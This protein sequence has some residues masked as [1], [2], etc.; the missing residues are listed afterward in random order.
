MNENSPIWVS[1]TAARRAVQNGPS[2]SQTTRVHT[3]QLA[4]HHQTDDRPEEGKVADHG[5]WV[6]EGAD[7]DE[8]ERHERIAQ[9][10]QAR[11]RL[12]GVVRLAD[13]Q[14]RQEGPQGEGESR[15]LRHRRRPQP[16][17]Q[18]DQQKQLLVVGAGHPRQS[19]ETTLEAR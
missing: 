8:E 17:G 1:P 15:G 5:A 11:Q 3:T 14:P 2:N 13:E 4:D 19:G 7:G 6:D 18:G 16:D 10:E 9:G 12:V